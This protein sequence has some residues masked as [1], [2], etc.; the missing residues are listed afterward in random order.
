MNLIILIKII[1]VK[2]LK[3]KNLLVLFINNNNIYALSDIC[4]AKFEFHFQIWSATIKFW[5]SLNATSHILH[6]AQSLY[7]MIHHD[8]KFKILNLTVKFLNLEYESPSAY[9]I[10]STLVGKK[11]LY[12]GSPYDY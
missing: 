8:V 11:K 12:Y 6:S 3:L 9:A 1:T 4:G 5:C 2:C 7:I 10:I